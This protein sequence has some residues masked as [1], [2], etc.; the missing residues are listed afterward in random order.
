MPD[1]PYTVSISIAWT[2]TVTVYDPIFSKIVV[3]AALQGQDGNQI[4][5]GDGFSGGTNAK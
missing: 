3:I 2:S 5:G 4:K 1:F